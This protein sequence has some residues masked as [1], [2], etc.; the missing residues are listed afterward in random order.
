M[1]KLQPIGRFPKVF[2]ELSID[3]GAR[4][5]C[6]GSGARFWRRQ[7][8]WTGKP[9]FG[10]S[11]AAPGIGFGELIESEIVAFGG[12]GETQLALGGH[13]GEADRWI[14][15]DGWPRG[16]EI[17]RHLDGAAEAVIAR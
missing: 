3:V 16:L 7:L 4:G 1:A 10:F 14:S 12:S 13:F 2:V 11:A 6:S 5:N 9:Q 17:L 8:G 15:V